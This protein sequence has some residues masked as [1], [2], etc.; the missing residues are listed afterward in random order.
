MGRCKRRQNGARN[1][2]LPP[3]KNDR[4]TVNTQQWYVTEP[5]LPLRFTG[6]GQD[7]VNFPPP[8]VAAVVLLTSFGVCALIILTQR[9]HGAHSLDHD[10]NG[11][12]KLHQSPVPRVGGIGLALGLLVGVWALFETHSHAFGLASGLLLSA[13]PA[14]AAG[15]VEDL[16]KRVS[17][18]TRLY[19]SFLSAGLAAW[20]L[21]A[22]LMRLHTP[23]LDELMSWMPAAVLFTCFAVGGMTN[24]INII[25]GLNGLASGAV[26]LML[27]GLACIAWQAGDAL[28]IQLCL[29]GMAAM[30][31]F[32]LLNYP[33]GRI[34]LGDGGAYLA[35]FWLSECAV[36]LLHRNPTVSTWAVLLCVLYPAWETTYSIYR[37]HVKQKVSSGMPD[38]DHFHH[39]IFNAVKFIHGSKE[40]SWVR[41]GAS[42]AFVWIL[43]CCCQL[44]AQLTWNQHG[45]S[46]I[47]ITCFVALYLFLYGNLGRQDVSST[48]K[49]EL[50]TSTTGT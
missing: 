40:R 9:W 32:I 37:R 46:L 45:A 42:T 43:V 23:G 8:W 5:H 48:L 34:F 49:A 50:S 15:L 12:Q 11:A 19:A 44:G 28:V 27:G 24:A 41:H 47:L 1:D 10:L 18:R 26:V 22:S 6:K 14:F 3:C 39:R 35:G 2:Q 36:L 7:I 13:T 25:D 17:V 16:T 30:G 38:M 21:D 31:G 4:T 20:L 33:F 29:W